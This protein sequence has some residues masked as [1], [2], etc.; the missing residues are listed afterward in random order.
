MTTTGGESGVVPGS[1]PW[2][3]NTEKGTIR[4]EATVR[5]TER[6]RPKDVV[7]EKRKDEEPMLQL[8]S[9]SGAAT[10]LVRGGGRLGTGTTAVA[11]DLSTTAITTKPG[12]PIPAIVRPS[13]L[14]LPSTYIKSSTPAHLPPQPTATTTHKPIPG[15]SKSYLNTSTTTTKQPA[16]QFHTQQP[17]PPH[18][19]TFAATLASPPV[20]TG[21]PAYGLSSARGKDGLTD[22]ERV[23]KEWVDAQK[24]ARRVRRRE[25]KRAAAGAAAAMRAGAEGQGQAGLTRNDEQ[26]PMSAA[27]AA[28]E[29]IAGQAPVSRN[30]SGNIPAPAAGTQK[31]QP[32]APSGLDDRPRRKK[33]IRN[34][35]EGKMVG[36]VQVGMDG[37]VVEEAETGIQRVSG[38]R[39]F[40]LFPPF[41]WTRIES[42]AYTT[43][44]VIQIIIP[45]PLIVSSGGTTSQQAKR[46]VEQQEQGRRVKRVKQSRRLVAGEEGANPPPQGDSSVRVNGRRIGNTNVAD[47]DGRS[48]AAGGAGTTL[49]RHHSHLRERGGGR[50]TRTTNLLRQASMRRRNVWDDL[51]DLSAGERAPPPAFGAAGVGAN[52]GGRGLPGTSPLAREVVHEGADGG[53]SGNANGS[54]NGHAAPNGVGGDND[55]LP[56]HPDMDP[57]DP[58][59]PFP[60]GEEPRSQPQ[61]QQQGG[62]D[63]ERTPVPPRSPPPSFEFAVA[64]FQVQAT[65]A[66]LRR[67]STTS[68]TSS[69]SSVV[70]YGPPTELQS[71]M[72][73]EREAWE[74]DISEGFSLEERLDRAA[75]R[76]KLFERA[77]QLALDVT[78][79]MQPAS[80]AA[81]GESTKREILVRA[82]E[83]V[84]RFSKEE[85]GKGKAVGQAVPVANGTDATCTDEGL[86]AA[87]EPRQEMSSP[88]QVPVVDLQDEEAAPAKVEE[89]KPSRSYIK[90]SSIRHPEPRDQVIS[91]VKNDLGRTN[92]K[93][94]SLPPLLINSLVH[95]VL[96]LAVLTSTPSTL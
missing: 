86:Q 23:R 40:S 68:S 60:E 64:Q 13:T 21:T 33:K 95:P 96:A 25:E 37:E 8:Q 58:P 50:D 36:G 31:D 30:Y 51:G 93:V 72:M 80:D 82:G 65:T 20:I 35:D 34:R 22:A 61:Q 38:D 7:A 44:T 79:G 76:A 62:N 73:E 54:M 24:E 55:G 43:D 63:A 89:G 42:L 69:G 6:R 46:S 52:V 1:F 67:G 90:Q 5:E 91:P 19:T 12:N 11:A 84:S 17:L 29:R 66:G 78:P 47:V 45:Q 77:N 88:K 39:S 26:A 10:E 3:G 32:V 18:P 9:A 16:F 41:P 71:R 85:K 4:T 53:R 27:A 94:V 49:H 81:A 59:P 70:E 2:S 57:S 56:L 87:V 48:G 74:R 75:Q 28:D 92:S 14:V 15:V 83:P